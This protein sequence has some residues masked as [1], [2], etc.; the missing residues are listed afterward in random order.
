MAVVEENIYSLMV[1][2][3]GDVTF[4]CDVIKI[5]NEKI[6]TVADIVCLYCWNVLV[7][8]RVVARNLIW[9]YTF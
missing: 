7:D 9:G 1:A 5:T 2:N 3:V 8:F 4:F 6:N